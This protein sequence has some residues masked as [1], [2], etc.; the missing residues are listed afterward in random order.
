M[1]IFITSPCFIYLFTL[2]LRDKLSLIIL[3]TVTITAIPIL[4]YYGVGFRQFGYRYS[5]D[6]L[7]LLYFLLMR[8]YYYQKGNLSSAFKVLVLASAF[9]NLYIF[10]YY[11]VL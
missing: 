4:L 6:F 5:L 7:P 2:K 1:S 9:L 8:N 10:S 11:Y 3:S